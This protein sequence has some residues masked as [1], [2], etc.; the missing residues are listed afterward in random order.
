MGLSQYG[1]LEKTNKFEE[2][3]FRSVREEMVQVWGLDRDGIG[4]M[5]HKIFIKR[6][7]RRTAIH[8]RLTQ[9]HERKYRSQLY[10]LQF[11]PISPCYTKDV[12]SLRA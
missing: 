12:G 3:V 11:Q 10:L 7:C 1:I 8:K 6:N 5:L 2:Q 4:S 9:C